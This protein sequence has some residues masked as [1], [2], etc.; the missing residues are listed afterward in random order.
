LTAGPKL[1]ALAVALA[2]AAGLAGCGDED[3]RD[4]GEEA[5]AFTVSQ[6][7]RSG[8]FFGVPEQ[9]EVE[10]V[11]RGVGG[12]AAIGAEGAEPGGSAGAVATSALARDPELLLGPEPW[13]ATI[14]GAEVLPQSF[15]LELSAPAYDGVRQE[16]RFDATVVS[17]QPERPPAS[18]GAATLTITSS[19]PSGSLSGAAVSA[20][21][22]T[23]ETGTR[24]AGALIE[25]R[26][27]GKGI[28]TAV[29]GADGSF[30]VGPLPEG[31]YEIVG[32]LPGYERDRAAV[33][34]TGG[35]SDPVELS[36]VP[37]GGTESVPPE[38][39]GSPSIS[40]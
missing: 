31:D 16:L 19:L 38:D 36:L 11:L 17:G 9:G 4:G 22:T 5:P 12:A 18:F 35:G 20:G 2:F 1:A 3:D 27:G 25:V 30:R 14:G 39:A 6:P 7:T 32:S 37:V 33:G 10:L 21:S 34:L 40:E 8:S 28:A 29:T 24:L 15:E 13:A 26:L 23:E